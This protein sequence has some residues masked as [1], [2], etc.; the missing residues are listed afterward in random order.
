MTDIFKITALGGRADLID[1]PEE[2]YETQALLSQEYEK[3]G[4]N[5]LQINRAIELIEANP[6]RSFRIN[7]PLILAGAPA[8]ISGEKMEDCADILI[9]IPDGAQTVFPVRSGALFA[10]YIDYVALNEREWIDLVLPLATP[11]ANAKEERTKLKEI[12]L[13][14]DDVVSYEYDLPGF[15][16]NLIPL[17]GQQDCTDE[18]AT[19]SSLLHTLSAEGYLKF[20]KFDFNDAQASIPLYHYAAKICERDGDECYVVDPWRGLSITEVS[21]WEFVNKEQMKMQF[22]PKI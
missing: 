1:T 17:R 5:N 2:I 9:P 12:A 11:A 3:F 13:K 16:G 22:R 10:N 20:H 6:G 18:T 19:L 8:C 4:E 15:L 14:F 21:L 7:S